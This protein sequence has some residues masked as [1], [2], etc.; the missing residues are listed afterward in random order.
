MQYLLIYCII[1]LAF[2]VTVITTGWLKAKCKPSTK[3]GLVFLKSIFNTPQIK[4]HF[5]NPLFW[6][7]LA[8]FFVA[9]LC[10]IFPVDVIMNI[11]KLFK[12]KKD[13]VDE[14]VKR[15]F[16]DGN[17]IKSDQEVNN[18][19]PYIPY[20]D[21]MYKNSI[22]FIPPPSLI[23][24]L[25]NT[26]NETQ[27]ARFLNAGEVDLNPETYPLLPEGILISVENINQTI[28]RE[29]RTSYPYK[30]YL[31]S[32]LEAWHEEFIIDCLIYH[33]GDHNKDILFG[34]TYSDKKNEEFN[35]HV[36]NYV[37]PSPNFRTDPV[38][39][40]CFEKMNYAL[41]ANSYFELGM[42]PGETIK[43]E[44]IKRIN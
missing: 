8:I 3:M 23:L 1:A 24:T 17:L 26:T 5:F 25:T 28:G 38:A 18:K 4:A 12:K 41:N 10:V 11:Q 42:H 36:N 16:D 40:T 9:A 37:S 19:Q 31:A 20:D 32:I 6:V 29:I 30:E 14:Y 34:Y 22:E 35:I 27:R 44:L 13:P 39:V 21:T 43:I 15:I 33:E 7:F 2:E